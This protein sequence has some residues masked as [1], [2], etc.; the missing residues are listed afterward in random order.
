MIRLNLS[1]E[2]IILNSR[3]L[4]KHILRENTLPSFILKPIQ[5]RRK[6]TILAKELT[7]TKSFRDLGISQL[8][9]SKRE[10]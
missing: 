8:Y 6:D 9:G 10:D 2:E 1:L 4:A 5:A 7:K 3:R